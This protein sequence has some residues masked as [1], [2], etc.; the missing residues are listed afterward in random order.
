MIVSA[1]IVTRGDVDL[2]PILEALPQEWERLVWDNGARELRF[3]L[4]GHW[5]G[6]FWNAGIKDLAVYGR[7]AALEHVQTELVYVQDDD[8][9]VSDPEALVAAWEPGHVVCNMPPEFRHAFYEEHALVGFGAV[10]ERGLPQ[11]AFERLHKIAVPDQSAGH[12]QWFDIP[13]FHRCADVAFTALSPR[14]LCDVPKENLPWAEAPG[15]MF[16]QPEHVAER[17]R[18]L[19]LA[20][21][22]RDA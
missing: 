18:M 11:R 3:L 8:C 7:Y 20:L 21:R 19:E 9:I 10:F 16:R 22:G 17:K 15:R 13:W 1:V 6:R 12:R 4:P 2:S 14:I 5:R